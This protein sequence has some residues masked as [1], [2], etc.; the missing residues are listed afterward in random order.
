MI[1]PA[2]SSMV[3]F[4]F[5]LSLCYQPEE[6]EIC[7]Y[8]TT[9]SDALLLLPPSISSTSHVS[10]KFLIFDFGPFLKEGKLTNRFV[11]V[12]FRFKG[13]SEELPKRLFKPGEETQVHQINNNCKMIFKLFDN[14]LGFSAR[15]IHGFLCREL[16]TYKDHELWFVFARRPLRFSLLEFHA[17]TGLQCDTSLSLKELVDWDDDGGFWSLVIRTNKGISIFELWE[18]H[19]AAVKMQLRQG[20]AS[21]HFNN[22]QKSGKI[23]PLLSDGI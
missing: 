22:C 5:R 19:R 16:L 6:L 1:R 15:V 12:V 14:G 20:S 21:F 9:S 4:Y 23:V 2:S 8:S 10:K 3:F 18:H 17:V 13:M 7:S 11:F